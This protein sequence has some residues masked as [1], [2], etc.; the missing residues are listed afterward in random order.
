ME[1]TK[2]EKIKECYTHWNGINK[3]YSIWAK[4]HNL[5]YYSLS[6]LYSIYDNQIDCN[7]KKICEEWIMP[8]Q[9]VN[10]ILS[11][12]ERRGYILFEKDEKDKRNK[13]IKLTESGLLYIENT[14]TP[15]FE[16][17]NKVLDRMDDNMKK[18]MIE[19]NN[20]F[21]RYLRE[22]MRKDGDENAEA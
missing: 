17:E 11:D 5:T 22:E 6:T 9:T 10:T 14:L 18:M 20:L 4:E 13:L 15:L 21:F 7:Q 2:R 12:F 1:S 3:L 19:S 8:K 16:I